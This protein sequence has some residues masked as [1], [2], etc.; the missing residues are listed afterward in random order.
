MKSLIILMASFSPSLLALTGLQVMEDVERN[1]QAHKNR[2]FEVEMVVK[3]K[4]GKSRSKVFR[5][6]SKS[7]GADNAKTKIVFLGPPDVKGTAILTHKE[8]ESTAQWMWLPALRSLKQIKGEEKNTSFMG[9]DYTKS[10][11]AGRR[12]HQDEHSLLTSQD[13]YHF[14]ESIPKEKDALYA[15][16]KYKVH[17]KTSVVSQVEFFDK[18]GSK[19]KTLKTQK[20][21]K[22]G[23]AYIITKS[24]MTNHGRGGE[25]V[26][27]VSEV[28]VQS[29]IEEREVGLASLRDGL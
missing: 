14:I 25:T 29:P 7:K 2:T 23:S 9:S 21:K 16:L 26:L 28:D 10:D 8:P 20:V 15:K 4:S 17:A 3:D 27:T 1:S 11:I 18:E 6:T 5:M 13:G 12:S 22:V 24:T 19:M